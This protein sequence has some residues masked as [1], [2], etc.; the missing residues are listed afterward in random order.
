MKKSILLFL[1][2]IL[3]LSMSGCSQIADRS[4]W[5]DWYKEVSYNAYTSDEYEYTRSLLKIEGT[6][7]KFEET[8][9]SHYGKENTSCY[10]VYIEEENSKDTWM[11][12]YYTDAYGWIPPAYWELSLQAIPIAPSILE[13]GEHIVVYGYNDKYIQTSDDG[14]PEITSLR[15]EYQGQLYDCIDEFGG[16][17]VRTYEPSYPISQKIKTNVK[18]F[19]FTTNEFIE[20]YNELAVSNNLTGIDYNSM[21]FSNY[22]PNIKGYDILNNN[23]EY[24]SASVFYVYFDYDVETEKVISI[25]IT[26]V[27]GY[28]GWNEMNEKD[29][30]TAVEGFSTAVMTVDSSLSLERAKKI[31]EKTQ[32]ILTKSFMPVVVD[33]VSYMGSPIKERHSINIKLADS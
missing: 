3:C 11:C 19:D 5:Q 30:E 28:D 18:A 14:V 29:K 26:Y 27:F 10:I 7:V 1:S 6:I 4:K 22:T 9:V 16:Y 8:K 32:T 33:G 2:L 31:V 20:R 15:L 12:T 23:E 21:I 25:N 13:I 24:L 17:A